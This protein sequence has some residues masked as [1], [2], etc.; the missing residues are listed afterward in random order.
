MDG[1]ELP[2]EL[3][4][5]IE[6]LGLQW[7]EAKEFAI[8]TRGGDWVGFGTQARHHAEAS[9]AAVATMQSSNHSDG[10]DAFAGYF[11]KVAGSSGYTFRSTMTDTVTGLAL[12]QAGVLVLELKIM[13]MV[14]LASL[15]VVIAAASAVAVETLGTSL[16]AAAVYAE[17]IYAAVILAQ[18]LTVVALREIGAPLANLIHDLLD[19]QIERLQD[20]PVHQSVDAVEVFRPTTTKQP[21]KP[22]TTAAG[23]TSAKTPRTGVPSTRAQSAKRPSPWA[24]SRPGRCITSN[25]ETTSEPTSSM[26]TRTAPE[27]SGT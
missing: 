21:G 20:R 6:S 17:E 11:V 23:P 3:V 14:A 26:S 2:A 1:L 8:M 4:A 27:R 24:W 25:G 16:A 15:A 9:L 18:R 22:S 5:I 10:L 12:I 13:T 19:V 7:P